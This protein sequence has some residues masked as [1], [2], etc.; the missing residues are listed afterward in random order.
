MITKGNAVPQKDRFKRE[1][2]SSPPLASAVR[3]TRRETIWFPQHGQAVAD[4]DI[5]PHHDR[6]YSTASQLEGEWQPWQKP[7]V[8]ATLAPP[9]RGPGPSRTRNL[10]NRKRWPRPPC[11]NR[12]SLPH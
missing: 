1:P 8:D 10:Q 9:S 3:C 6:L 11:R 7:K 2:D 4:A 12:S 5:P